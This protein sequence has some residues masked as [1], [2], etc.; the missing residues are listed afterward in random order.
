MMNGKFQLAL[1]VGLIELEQTLRDAEQLKVSKR[2]QQLFA[3][4]I[5]LASC[6]M[7]LAEC[8]VTRAEHYK[9]LYE[10]MHKCH[11]CMLI[12]LD[13]QGGA[14]QDPRIEL[15]MSRLS[16]RERSTQRL[17]ILR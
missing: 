14:E 7:A 8:L 13:L 1:Q 6:C 16:K 5:M 2:V 17:Q 9:S 12:I 3:Q 4:V 11:T 10:S 15:L